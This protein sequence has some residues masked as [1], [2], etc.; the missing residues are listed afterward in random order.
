MFKMPKGPFCQ[1]CGMPIDNE[2]LT[3]SN[4]DGSSSSEYCKYCFQQGEFTAPDITLEQMIKKC[5]AILQEKTKMPPFQ[6]A[7]IT[8][9]LIPKLKRWQNITK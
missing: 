5:S 9:G 3:G 8:N 6:A 1:S 7:M 4:S 2:E